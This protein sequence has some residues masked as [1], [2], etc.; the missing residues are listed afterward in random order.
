MVCR[1]A[2]EGARKEKIKCLPHSCIEAGYPKNLIC[3]SDIIIWLIEISGVFLFST[4][5]LAAQRPTEWRCVL[6]LLSPHKVEQSEFADSSV[7]YTLIECLLV[8]EESIL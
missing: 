8:R 6:T 4:G 7:Q 2:G 5:M 3:N 1:G